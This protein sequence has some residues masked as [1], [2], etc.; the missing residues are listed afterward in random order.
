[1]VQVDVTG[2]LNGRV[3]VA[4]QLAERFQSHLVG[5]SSWVPRPPLAVEGVIIDVLTAEDLENLTKP[6]NQRGEAFK[7]ATGIGR[8]RVEWRSAQ[9]DPTG[10]IAREARAADLVIISR[11]R[12]AFDPRILPDPAYG[13]GSLVDLPQ[14]SVVVVARVQI[15]DGGADITLRTGRLGDLVQQFLSRRNGQGQAA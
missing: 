8:H 10:Y 14:V 11:Q 7:A 2:E 5:V 1:M 15:A 6:L 12:P 9:D 3:R 4:A 13:R